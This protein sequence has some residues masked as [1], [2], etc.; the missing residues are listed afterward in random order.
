MIFPKLVLLIFT[1]AIIFCAKKLPLFKSRHGQKHALT[2][3]N[4]NKSL[5]L[6][7]TEKSHTRS[8]VGDSPII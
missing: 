3:T 5:S 4:Y 2:D 1:A 8:K 6:I 7:Q